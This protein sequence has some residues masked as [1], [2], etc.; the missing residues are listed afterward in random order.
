M[1]E[2]LMNEIHNAVRNGAKITIGRNYYGRTRLKIS[3]GPFGF[4]AKRISIDA[5]ELQKVFDT[6]N[7]RR[8]AA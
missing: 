5:Q 8:V 3:Q 6:I 2:I 4:R 7:L 1:S